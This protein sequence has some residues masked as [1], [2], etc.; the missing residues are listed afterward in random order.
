MNGTVTISLKDYE[1][2]VEAKKAADGI[3]HASKLSTKELQVFL[4]YICS[5]ADLQPLVDEFNRQ[6][7]TSK[8]VVDSGR[9]R[10]MLK[11]DKN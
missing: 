8:I 5:R 6:S 11:D 10:I 3:L 1:D 9:A 7:G 2:L 4:S